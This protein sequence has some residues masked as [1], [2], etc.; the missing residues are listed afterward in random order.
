MPKYSLIDIDNLKAKA[1]VLKWNFDGWEA[2]WD[3]YIKEYPEKMDDFR[4][5]IEDR[6]VANIK[7]KEIFSKSIEYCKRSMIPRGWQ[8][9]LCEVI[10][11][12]IPKSSV[13]DYGCGAGNVGLYFAQRG[14]DVTFLDIKGELTEFVNWRL[15]RRNLKAKI[16][17][18][19]SKL[20]NYGLVFM[21]NV[22]EHLEDAVNVCNK[23]F[24]SV[25][26]GGYFCYTFNSKNEG[27]D[28]VSV[29]FFYRN[30]R[31][32]LEKYFICIP[33]TGNILWKKK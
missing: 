7:I 30:I 31:P 23:V 25:K 16:L 26:P 28:I 18:H 27:L 1:N 20:E 6:L 8:Q 15:K 33:Q 17:Y 29:E 9:Y 22:I 12:N 21:V 32:R 10:D 24:D 14:H 11:T 4:E 2:E 5:S 13:L 19:D 3:D